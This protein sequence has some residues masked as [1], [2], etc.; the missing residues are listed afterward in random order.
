MSGI[1]QELRSVCNPFN[2]WS[3]AGR[4]GCIRTR[5]SVSGVSLPTAKAK[6]LLPKIVIVSLPLASPWETVEV[7]DEP[8][9][10]T[11]STTGFK[12]VQQR[13]SFRLKKEGA[14]ECWRMR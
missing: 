5:K 11:L 13:M 9:M 3:D 6:E 7:W 12:S 10:L 8:N 14:S 2:M 4:A 1:D